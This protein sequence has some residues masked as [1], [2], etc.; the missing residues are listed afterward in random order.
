MAL[1]AVAPDRDNLD[2]QEAGCKYAYMRT[3]IDLPDDLFRQA[4]ARA[5]SEGRKLKELFTD[6]VERG[7]ATDR[8]G[9]MSSVVEKRRSP[10][11]VILKAAANSGCT[12]E[13]A[14]TNRELQEI[15]DE[16]DA[17]SALR[18]TGR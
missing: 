8:E 17:E 10:L 11:P 15:L 2:R 4:K 1:Q 12:S 9:E 6:Y 18:F 14:L 3:T 13:P 16:E 5:A 7:L